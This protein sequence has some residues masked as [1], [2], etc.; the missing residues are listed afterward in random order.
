MNSAK[1]LLCETN[2]CFHTNCIN[3]FDY[4]EQATLACVVGLIE[5]KENSQG[6]RNPYRISKNQAEFNATPEL[7]SIL[8]MLPDQHLKQLHIGGKDWLLLVGDIFVENCIN[9]S[10][11]VQGDNEFLRAYINPLSAYL[12]KWSSTFKQFVD[13][14]RRI[15]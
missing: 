13:N 3:S 6:R 10:Y 1:C 5:K 2:H 11:I 12:T 14:S 8:K 7:K 9:E 4:S 15:V